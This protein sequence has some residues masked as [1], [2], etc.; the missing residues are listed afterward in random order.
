VAGAAA[1]DPPAVR[2]RTPDDFPLG[3]PAVENSV[4]ALDHLRAAAAD[5]PAGDINRRFN[6]PGPQNTYRWEWLTA[7]R[8]NID[9]YDKLA[10]EAAV[11]EAAFWREYKRAKH[12][13]KDAYERH[14]DEFRDF[15]Y[16]RITWR[17]WWYYT[18]GF[19]HFRW[20]KDRPGGPHL[21]RLEQSVCKAV[22]CHRDDLYRF[23]AWAD[24]IAGD[25]LP[26][27]M[28]LWLTVPLALLS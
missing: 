9:H 6:K 19:H 27:H 28:S 8:R 23:L 20:E 2:I 7:A 17:E 5:P 24:L 4:I 3:L 12:P 15:L 22:G 11:L 16:M 1:A 10:R 18:A 14:G 26:K 13:Q 25:L 21:H